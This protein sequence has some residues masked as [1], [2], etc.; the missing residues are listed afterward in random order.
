MTAFWNTRSAAS[1][2]PT[3][4]SA[5]RMTKRLF[6]NGATLRSPT[7]AS[8]ANR[9][10]VG[11]GTPAANHRSMQRARL[12]ASRALRSAGLSERPLLRHL[13]TISSTSARGSRCFRSSAPVT[14]SYFPPTRRIRDSVRE[15]LG[16]CVMRNMRIGTRDSIA[17]VISLCTGSVVRSSMS[18]M[19]R[20]AS[21]TFSRY[22]CSRSW[23]LAGV[24]SKTQGTMNEGRSRTS[25]TVWRAHFVSS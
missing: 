14:R 19:T 22:P 11:S 7:D 9:S 17:F 20:S 3:P 25:S 13:R 8:S 24:C 4:I 15:S 21:R 12:C 1:D 5:L 6:A 23:E 2:F 16:P 10:A 18:Q